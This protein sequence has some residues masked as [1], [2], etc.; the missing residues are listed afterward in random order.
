MQQKNQKLQTDVKF[1]KRCGRRLTKEES[2]NLGFGL[3][4]YRKHQKGKNKPLFDIFKKEGKKVKVL[5]SY[6]IAELTKAIK[7]QY[8]V[9]E[10][11]IQAMNDII[12]QAIMIDVV[13]KDNESLKKENDLLKT[14]LFAIQG[15]I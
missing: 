12:N 6:E 10:E 1:C 7:N 2:R 13:L 3:V 9:G 15:R 5:T 11:V 14:K 8:S 4:C